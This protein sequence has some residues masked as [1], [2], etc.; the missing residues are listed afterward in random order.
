MNAEISLT[1]PI[2]NSLTFVF[3]AI[4]SMIIGEAQYKPLQTAAGIAL[5]VLG[6]AICVLSQQPASDAV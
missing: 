1:V 6:V 4:T 3:T 5:T 2:C